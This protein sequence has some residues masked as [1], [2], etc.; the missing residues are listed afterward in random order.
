MSSEEQFQVG[1]STPDAIVKPHQDGQYRV[2]S[3]A[4]PSENYP[5]P[6]ISLR[7]HSAKQQQILHCV[8]DDTIN[9]LIEKFTRTVAFQPPPDGVILSIAKDLPCCLSMVLFHNRIFRPTKARTRRPPIR[10]QGDGFWLRPRSASQLA[11]TVTR[12]V[13]RHSSCWRRRVRCGLESEVMI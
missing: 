12:A 1:I 3:A 7:R 2:A 5:N 6:S 4:V 13:S 8:Q 9:K 10:P 11:G